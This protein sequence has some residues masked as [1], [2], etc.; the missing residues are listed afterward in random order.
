MHHQRMELPDPGVFVNA[1]DPADSDAVHPEREPADPI[2]RQLLT[3][4][5]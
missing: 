4:L 5:V 2:R 1:T 3:H